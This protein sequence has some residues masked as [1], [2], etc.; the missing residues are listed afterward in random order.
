MS[1]MLHRSLSFVLILTLLSIALV[2]TR[3]SPASGAAAGPVL[4]SASDQA[5]APGMITVTGEAFTPSG[6]IYVALYDK[7]GTSLHETRWITASSA[8]YGPNGSRDPASGFS[9]G[10]TLIESF[11]GLCGATLMVRAYD[12]QAAVWS[13]WLDVDP[14]V[15]GSVVYGPNGSGDPAMGFRAGC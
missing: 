10:G 13:N 11:G 4:S 5:F 8:V 12:Q 2:G 3:S 1:R 14:V 7:W 6:E 9:S 15:T